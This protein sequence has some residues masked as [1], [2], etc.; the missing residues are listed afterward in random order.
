MSYDVRRSELHGERL[1][2]P[3]RSPAARRLTRRSLPTGRYRFLNVILA[4]AVAGLAAVA[5][6]AVGSTSTSSTG[7]GTVRTAP[8]AR[9]VVLSSVSASGSVVAAAT[10]SVG[11]QT[12]GQ[13]TEV[14]VKP[15]QRVKA[16]QVL[17]RIDADRTPRPSVQQAQAALKTAQANLETTM[18][19]ETAQQRAADALSLT[20]DRGIGHAR[21]RSRS[22]RRSGS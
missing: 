2:G 22:R 17:G 20:P 10:I 13:L 11:F 9:G 14:D 1:L 12:A 18:T 5:Y 15:G 8:V 6:F 4:A 7:T 16:G 21:R 19:G 3:R